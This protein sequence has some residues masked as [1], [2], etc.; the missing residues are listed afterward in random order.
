MKS[1]RLII[2]EDE[3]HNSR[4]LTGMVN[5]LR[6][7]WEITAVLESVEESVEYLN[8][9]PA[10]DLIL[11]DIQLS[12]GISFSILNQVI[13]SANTHIIFTT[14]YD[15]YAIRAFKVNSVD[16]LLKP[17]KEEDLEL[18][19]Q[20]FESRLEYLVE[21][22]PTSPYGVDDY[23]ALVASILSGKK[24]YRTRFLISGIK[25]HIK[26]EVADVAYFHSRQKATFAVG[27]DLQEHLLDYTLEQLENELDPKI[28]YRANRQVIVNIDT[29]VKVSNAL[30]NKLVVRT[31]PPSEWEIVVSRLKAVDFKKWLGK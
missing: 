17:I 12:D 28:F 23:K 26:L 8:N 3:L 6:P 22:K 20:K 1:V 29:V 5:K 13:L 16:Y 10:P 9:T 25:D 24:E 14:A 19:F 27:F 18:A 21:L 31:N 2:I 7:E 30:G 15:Q 4:M 11:M